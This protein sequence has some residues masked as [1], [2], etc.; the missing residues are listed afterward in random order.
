MANSA[1]YQLNVISEI[2]WKKTDLADLDSQ[3][4]K[5]LLSAHLIPEI[6]ASITCL[7]IPKF[8]IFY[9]VNSLAISFLAKHNKIQGKGDKMGHLHTQTDQDYKA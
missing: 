5:H 4:L 1:I 9:T 2:Y 3:F 6:R 7:P 8:L